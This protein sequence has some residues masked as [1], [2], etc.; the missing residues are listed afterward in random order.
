MD[1]GE[2]TQSDHY[3]FLA[4]KHWLTDPVQGLFMSGPRR[5]L[6]RQIKALN[7]QRVL[8][9][10]CGS[11]DITRHLTRAGIETTGVD[12]SESMLRR[13]RQ[14]TRISHIHKL[15]V[16]EMD[17]HKEFDVAYISLAIHEMAPEVREQ[18]WQKMLQAVR[19]GGT[20]FVVDFSI[21]GVE[22][23][24]SRF[25]SGFTEL[26]EKNFLKSNPP[27]Y[28]NYKEFMQHGGV[29]E[30]LLQRMG[31]IDKAETFFADTM[32]VLAVTI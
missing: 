13:A 18:V 28:H 30:W 7:P 9:V 11:G 24:W 3:S 8:D 25:W 23:F 16:T 12:N 19:D 14:K 15:D 4:G 27:H 17:F 6:I 22:R 10:C 29:H 5:S 31:R 20:I 2:D 32:A 26:D 1:K 21:A